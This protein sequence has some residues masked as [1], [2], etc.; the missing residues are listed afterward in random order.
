MSDTVTDVVQEPEAEA[1]QPEPQV[2]EVGKAFLVV[3]KDNRI[4]GTSWK[5]VD[6]IVDPQQAV[7]ALNAIKQSMFD[8]GWTAQIVLAAQPQEEGKEEA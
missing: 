3:D 1:A 6:E 2:V 8:V 4:L 5:W 7:V